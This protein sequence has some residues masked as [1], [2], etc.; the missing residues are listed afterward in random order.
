M[1]EPLNLPM[2]KAR[3]FPFSLRYR[4]RGSLAY[5]VQG[6]S[7]RPAHQ[8]IKLQWAA[9]SIPIPNVLGCIGIGVRLMSAP[10]ADVGMFMTFV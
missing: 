2:A 6:R 10:G 8:S 9:Q 4:L 7:M 1:A 5:R 3:G